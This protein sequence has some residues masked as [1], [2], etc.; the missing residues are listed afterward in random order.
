MMGDGRRLMAEGGRLMAEGGWL[1]AEGGWLRAN[2]PVTRDWALG[3]QP[4]ALSRGWRR[5]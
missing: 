3:L 4:S 1:T 2:S 5:A